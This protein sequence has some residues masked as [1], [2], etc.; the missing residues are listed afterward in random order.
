[1]QEGEN[2][3]RKLFPEL[4]SERGGDGEE[5]DDV[6][7]GEQDPLRLGVDAAEGAGNKTVVEAADDTERVTG[8]RSR[9]SSGSGESSGAGF[10]RGRGNGQ[11]CGGGCGAHL[12]DLSGKHVDTVRHGFLNSWGVL[13]EGFG[14]HALDG[15]EECGLG[16]SK[17]DSV[18]RASTRRAAT[19]M[20]AT[21]WYKGAAAGSVRSRLAPV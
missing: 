7:E 19:R 21:A 18:A 12:G 8:N 1:M 11:K 4:E 10:D 20:V 2:R 17:T 5:Y 6:E 14:G 3:D 9:E 15:T 13:L 16:G